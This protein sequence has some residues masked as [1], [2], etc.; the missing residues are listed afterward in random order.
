MVTPE[1]PGATKIVDE[2]TG[3]ETT[4]FTE[5]GAWCR[6]ALTLGP[7][8]LLLFVMGTY[9]LYQNQKTNQSN[10]LSFRGSSNPVPSPHDGS[11]NN[12]NARA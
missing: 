11:I 1:I 9:V 2:G 12:N 5:E 3:D 10:G 6:V 8:F 4:V 7:T